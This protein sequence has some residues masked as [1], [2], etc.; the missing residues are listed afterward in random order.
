VIYIGLDD[1]DTLETRGTGHLARLIAADL[2]GT[3]PLAGVTRHQ[4]LLDPRVPY[5]AKNSAAA[6]MLALDEVDLTRLE[7]RVSAL[8]LDHHAAGSDPGLALAAAV[9]S[10]VVRFGN[11]VQREVVKRE[12]ARKLAAD[13][14]LAL[15]GL[16]GNHDG[17]IGALAA[18]GLAAG[19]EDGRYVWVGRARELHGPVPVG[20]VL[21]AGVDEVRTLSGE[22]VIT[23]DI[24]AEKL[25]PARRGSWSVLF[26]QK[27]ETGWRPLRLD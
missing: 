23:G 15:T 11:R 26:V 1:T 5:T 2:A 13:H 8:I 17:I 21:E 16:G 7:Q 27:S 9:P 3:Y 12:S 18:V 20:Q 25:R 14:S 19:G 4:L 6:I 22:I 10:E 24:L